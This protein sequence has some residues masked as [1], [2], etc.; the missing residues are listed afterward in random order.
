MWIE[1]IESIEF[2]VLRKS[3]ESIKS[4]TSDKNMISSPRPCSGH[5][6]RRP[7]HS[8]DH[9]GLFVFSWLTKSKSAQLNDT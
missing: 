7:L 5:K 4:G 8:G 1:S 3:I 6:K 9:S 2:T